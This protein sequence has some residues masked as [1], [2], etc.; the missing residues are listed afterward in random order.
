MNLLTM[1]AI[2]VVASVFVAA[3][4]SA[5]G[6]DTAPDTTTAER[7]R[8]GLVLGGGGARG[9]AHIGVLK[10]L[11]RL[12]IPVHAIAGTSMGAIVGGLYASGMSPA[13]LENVVAE[14]DW[15]QAL[16]DEPARSDLRYRRKQDKQRFPINPDLGFDSD[17]LKLPLGLIQG[18]RLDLILRRL[19]IDS[20]HIDDFDDLAIPFRAVASDIETGE[21]Y[22]MGRGDLA[23]AIRAS[24]SVIRST[25]HL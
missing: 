6:S 10:E 1:R 12:Q 22:V 14:M 13:E 21:A 20:S 19:T 11:E 3:A 15:A 2:A 17:G 4:A 23:T 18:Q 25:A 7:P 9:A 24:M 8:I 16:K 5:A